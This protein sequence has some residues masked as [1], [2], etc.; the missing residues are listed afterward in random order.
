MTTIYLSDEDIQ[1]LRFEEGMEK[2]IIGMID[3]GF[4]SNLISRVLKY[5]IEKIEEI[6]DRY[7]K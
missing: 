7:S 1:E 4:D 5:N 6:K 2:A 3:D